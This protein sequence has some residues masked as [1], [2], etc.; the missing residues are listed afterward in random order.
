VL[1]KR[2]WA[3]DAGL[4]FDEEQKNMSTEPKPAPPMIARGSD[5]PFGAPSRPDYGFSESRTETLAIR[6]MDL[7]MERADQG[8]WV[9]INGNP[10]KIDDDGVV[11]SGPMKGRKLDDAKGNGRT[12]PAQEEFLEKSRK[13]GFT[14]THNAGGPN[15][16]TGGKWQADKMGQAAYGFQTSSGTGYQV[17]VQRDE[18][19][20]GA[21]VDSHYLQFFDENDSVNITG[22][23]KA[24][25]VFGNV[26]P[27][28]V[29]YVAEKKP[30]VMYFSAAERSRQR[31]YDRLTKSMT[32]TLDSY[33]AYG[34]TAPAGR[35][36][37]I[38]KKDVVPKLRGTLGEVLAES[39]QGPAWEKIEPEF[40]PAWL[41]P[42]GWEDEEPSEEK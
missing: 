35:M 10:V 29:A 3:T 23:G 28:V 25:E 1:S 4:D 30:S 7:L 13:I 41:T 12:S 33:V 42:E 36:Y 39:T 22:S 5:V 14:S 40:D 20:N 34:Q 26:V 27:A 6:A 8:K 19:F 31:L 24:H 16:D 37:V 17:L 32:K 2:T 18:Q 9:T 38:A 11:L 21:D 15:F